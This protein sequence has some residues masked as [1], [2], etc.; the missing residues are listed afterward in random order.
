MQYYRLLDAESVCVFLCL[1]KWLF[2]STVRALAVISFENSCM[3]QFRGLACQDH[4]NL[5][6]K[7]IP[8]R[9]FVVLDVPRDTCFHRPKRWTDVAS[10]K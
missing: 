3:M 5:R 9:E 6:G 1:E 2:D 7:F 4:E 10:D 8:E